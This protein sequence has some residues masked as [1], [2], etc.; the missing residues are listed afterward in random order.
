[1]AASTVEVEYSSNAFWV[2]KRKSGLLQG[3]PFSSQPRRA[4]KGATFE[5][6]NSFMQGIP[7]KTC[8]R[9]PLWSR[10]L[11]DGKAATILFVELVG[12]GE[13]LWNLPRAKQLASQG[14]TVVFLTLGANQ[15][16]CVRENV[17]FR[18]WITPPGSERFLQNP[19]VGSY[20]SWVRQG[21]QRWRTRAIV[22]TSLIP[23]LYEIIQAESRRYNLLVAARHNALGAGLAREKLGAPLVGL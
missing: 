3:R 23:G 13:F 7:R 16:D 21:I 1:M 11:A 18:E 6:Q 22:Q 14:H 10:R 9:L 15:A 12:R 2:D 4:D 8:H 5:M 19:D 17:G 20:G